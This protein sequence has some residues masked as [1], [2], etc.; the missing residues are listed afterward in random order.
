MEECLQESYEE[1]VVP[2]RRRSIKSSKRA[3][4]NEHF[5]GTF[6]VLGSLKMPQIPVK[7]KHK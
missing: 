3:L 7:N 6:K 4:E 1:H 2:T 5:L